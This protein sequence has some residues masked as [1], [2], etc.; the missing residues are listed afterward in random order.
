MGERVGGLLAV[1]AVVG[2][3]GA[4]V[5][6]GRAAW[7]RIGRAFD[8]APRTQASR[9]VGR[10][11]TEG[12]A[13]RGAGDH[14]PPAPTVEPGPVAGEG[15]DIV[16]VGLA[17]QRQIELEWAR[18]D[19]LCAL[20]RQLLAAFRGDRMGCRR[21]GDVRAFSAREA[22]RLERAAR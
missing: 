3:G 10:Q 14:A 12:D 11:A 6:V 5:L 4:I 8:L 18:A 19:E 7:V 9:H 20:H 2:I 15:L 13:A 16:A 17:A 22:E 1:A 21:W